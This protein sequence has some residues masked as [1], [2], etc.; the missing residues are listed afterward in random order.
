MSTKSN[1]EVGGYTWKITDTFWF[2]DDHYH[3]LSNSIPQIILKD[4]DVVPSFVLEEPQSYGF[5]Y[6]ECWAF[7]DNLINDSKEIVENCPV[8][9][10]DT[11]AFLHG[12]LSNCNI[13]NKW[14]TYDNFIY[15]DEGIYIIPQGT[16]HFCFG[17][18]LDNSEYQTT[19]VYN[20][21]PSLSRVH[22]KCDSHNINTNASGYVPAENT[23]FTG[24]CIFDVYDQS[25]SLDK[26]SVTYSDSWL[27]TGKIA[28]GIVESN[29]TAVRLLWAN[30]ANYGAARTG[31]IYITVNNIHGESYTHTV[32]VNQAGTGG[33]GTDSGGSNEADDLGPDW[34]KMSASGYMPY[35]YCSTTGKTTPANPRSTTITVYKNTK[36]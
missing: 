13:F 9:V 21:V 26:I 29:Y 7:F 25:F 35:Y 17:S 22:F 2:L 34:V 28:T 30:S 32:T 12:K 23:T 11:G 1:I 18:T 20:A 4:K 33:S 6:M 8:Y 31:Y 24:L 10:N 36:T 3:I 14:Q 15:H 19:L 5:E 27:W 16:K